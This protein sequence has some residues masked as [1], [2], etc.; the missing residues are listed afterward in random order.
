MN[1][2]FINKVWR[3]GCRKAEA[4]L[5][6]LQ[7]LAP[8]LEAMA[9]RPAELH[10]ETTNLC[11][12]DCVFCPYQFQQRPIETMNDTV[13]EK[14]LTDF[15]AEGGGDVFFTP[16]VG[17]ALIDKAIIQRIQRARSEPTVD[18]IK[19]I[20]NMILA[21]K[22]GIEPLLESGLSLLMISIAGF[23]KDMYQR[24]YR[25]PKYA[26]V[27][28]N[29]LAL[30]ETN[31][32]LGNPVEIVI[33]LRPDRPLNEIMDYPD[34]RDVMT[35]EPKLDFTWAFTSAGGRI[36]REALPAAMRLRKAPV[37]KEACV[38]T[39]NGPMVLADGRVLACSCVAAM[40]ADPGLVLGNLSEQSLG[41]IWRS[42][43]SHQLRASFRASSKNPQSVLN[44]TCASCEM[45]RN[46]DL[47]R[48]REGRQR[49]E[50]NHQRGHG[51]IPCKRGRQDAGSLI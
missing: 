5:G 25:S 14:A 7:P 17:D 43:R 51:E 18:R 30:L 36:T 48:T 33:G 31:Q 50:Y 9:Q 15:V 38:E 45:Y 46:L 6:R 4:L 8:T 12:A 32:R 16:I 27:L 19:L 10:L 44:P 2:T 3:A 13:F 23:D 20:T 34:M 24:V 42:P 37:K 40:D 26:Q 39:Y 47:Y 28:R 11:N 21:H 35:Y 29:T 22:R 41:D 1:S 49:A